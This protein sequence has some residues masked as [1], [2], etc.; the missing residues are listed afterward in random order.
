MFF[1]YRH[2]GPCVD[3]IIESGIKKIIIGSIDPNPKVNNKS[4]DK[5]KNNKTDVELIN[6]NDLKKRSDDLIEPFKMYIK[7][8]LSIRNS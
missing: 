3:K 4:I 5:L 6:D 8:S 2:T 1:S 7:N